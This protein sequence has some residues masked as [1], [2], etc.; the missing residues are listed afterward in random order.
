VGTS[1]TWVRLGRRGCRGIQQRSVSARAA[2]GSTSGTSFAT[3]A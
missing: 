1:K 2:A 3:R